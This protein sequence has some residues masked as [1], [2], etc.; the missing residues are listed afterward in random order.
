[1]S[2]AKWKHVQG[3][4]VR[5]WHSDVQLVILSVKDSYKRDIGYLVGNVMGI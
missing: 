3:E 4:K 5:T 1:M 2:L